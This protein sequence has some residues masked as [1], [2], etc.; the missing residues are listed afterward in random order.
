MTSR[1]DQRKIRLM[2]RLVEDAVAAILK[3]PDKFSVQP[4]GEGQIVMDRDGL[5]GLLAYAIGRY[6]GE[7]QP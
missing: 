7:R 1:H 3:D 2:E 6:E 4:F 5:K